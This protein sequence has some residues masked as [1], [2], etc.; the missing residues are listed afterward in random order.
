MKRNRRNDRSELANVIEEELGALLRAARED[1]GLT[2]DEVA[3]RLGVTVEEIV[4]IEAHTGRVTLGMLQRYAELLG[5]KVTLR[6][7]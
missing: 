3:A 5:K 6:F 1:Q 7:L 4:R 2:R